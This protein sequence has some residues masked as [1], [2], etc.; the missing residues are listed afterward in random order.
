MT[1][2][3]NCFKNILVPDWLTGGGAGSN[4]VPSYARIV[5]KTVQ[6]VGGD[7]ETILEKTDGA[8]NSE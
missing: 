6:N 1:M 5:C 7:E 2:N 8:L 3:L 4:N